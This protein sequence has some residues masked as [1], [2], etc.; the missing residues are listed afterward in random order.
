MVLAQYGQVP[1]TSFASGD[2]NRS[3]FR[4]MTTAH[5]YYGITNTWYTPTATGGDSTSG[6][7]AFTGA[8]VTLTAGTSIMLSLL[9]EI[10]LVMETSWQ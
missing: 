3:S 8:V 2:I 10:Q 1:G 5:S 7:I 6:A 9:L 4:F